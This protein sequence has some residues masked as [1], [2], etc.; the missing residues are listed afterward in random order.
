MALGRL[1][2][3]ASTFK[4]CAE[5]LHQKFLTIADDSACVGCQSAGFGEAILAAWLQT[6]WA[7]FSR[8]LI[9]ASALGTRRRKG[10]SIRA[11]AGARSRTDAEKI[12][13][14]AASSS[15]CKRGAPYAIWHDPL[16]AIE[17]GT[18]LGIG[19]L[20]SLENALGATLV[21][22]QITVFRNYLIHPG[23]QTRQGTRHANPTRS[24]RQS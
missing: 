15:A 8:D 9:V 13:K 3:A 24:F 11:V 16:F 18:S 19:N 21:P 23:N 10:K 17:V 14:A 22:R 2:V 7:N 4:S 5:T 1:D 20:Q 6:T 12:V